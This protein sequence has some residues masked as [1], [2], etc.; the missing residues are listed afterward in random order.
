[1]KNIFLTGDRQ[2]GKS[3]IVKKVVSYLLERKGSLCLG[4]F[5]TI[6]HFDNNSGRY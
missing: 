1:M 5:L 4:G 2:V 6:S 3:T